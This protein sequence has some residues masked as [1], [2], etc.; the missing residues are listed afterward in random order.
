MF[1]RTQCPSCSHIFAAEISDLGKKT[2][3][4][5]CGNAFVIRGMTKAWPSETRNA[6]NPEQVPQPASE[7]KKSRLWIVVLIV[8]AMVWFWGG[9]SESE[10][11]AYWNNMFTTS[12]RAQLP[13]WQKE[14][15]GTIRRLRDELASRSTN[16]VDPLA[17]GTSER[18]QGF[19][20]ELAVLYDHLNW[21]NEHP[22]Q[23]AMSGAVGGTVFPKWQILADE[24]KLW[25]VEF[26]SFSKSAYTQLSSELD[27]KLN[28]PILLPVGIWDQHILSAQSQSDVLD[29]LGT[30][31][32]ALLLGG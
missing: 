19:L 3:C 13:E 15:P 21:M 7:T 8:I 25:A 4:K 28:A 23:T 10:T 29:K 20:G 16:G 27:E 22:N 26:N 17:K 2:K 9:N 5:S 11:V 18:L 1:E 14:W 31:G 24:C 6:G 32:G 12:E 30:I